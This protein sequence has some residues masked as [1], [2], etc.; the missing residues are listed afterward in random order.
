M[1]A[2]Y[3]FLC[4]DWLGNREDKQEEADN[5]LR[6]Q[7]E[8]NSKPAEPRRRAACQSAAS[9]GRS[10]RPLLIRQRRRLRPLRPNEDNRGITS[11]LLQPR[12]VPPPLNDVHVSVN[13][14]LFTSQR[15][16]K[17]MLWKRKIDV[18]R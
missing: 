7:G 2:F 9:R 10:D 5:Q 17:M 16:Q 14:N 6:E 15:E 4:R 13:T 11:Y 3:I 1:C 12:G 8:C 18:L